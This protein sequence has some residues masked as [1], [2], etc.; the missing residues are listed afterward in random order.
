MSGGV[1]ISSGGAISVDSGAIRDI[2]RRL[3]L[4][5]GQVNDAAGMVRDA[6]QVLMRISGARGDELVGQLMASARRLNGTSFEGAW[7]AR[8]AQSMAD[9]FELVE[10][11]GQQAALAVTDPAAA[12][13]LEDRIEQL[14]AL[15]FVRE[16][17]DQLKADWLRH[18]FDG[19]TDQPW[20]DRLVAPL[21]GVVGGTMT[22]A[23][24]EALKLNRGVLPPGTVLTGDAP[25][26]TVTKVSTG[27]AQPVRNLEDTMKRVPNGHK[28]Q[29]VVEKYTMSDKSVRYVTY[30]DG[31]RPDGGP[32]E[33]WDMESNAKMYLDRQKSAS[34]QAVLAALAAAGANAGD[35]VDIVGYSQGAMIGAFTAMDSPYDVKTVIAAGDPVAPTLRSGQ[36]IV[37]LANIADP[38]HALALGGQFGGTGSPDSFTVERDIPG[39]ES[40]ID[41]HLYP[42]YVETA[43]QAD[44]SGDVRVQKLHDTFFAQLG[45]ATSVERMEFSAKRG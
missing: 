40:P 29:I 1:E 14:E 43:R 45:E 44:A 17:V 4:L 8:S 5:A 35:Q 27:D 34:Q 11:R 21:A 16:R 26:V 28:G 6:Q 24:G 12:L 30:I 32:D 3:S 18:R 31:T 25:P 37:N 33:P 15:P 7:R 13:R 39:R 22:M 36:T 20:D 2:G 10:L 38:A 9:V 41:P 42:E 19:I 23:I